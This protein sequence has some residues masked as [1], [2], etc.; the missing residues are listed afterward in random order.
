MGSKVWGLGSRGWGLEATVL[1]SRCKVWGV[2][3]RGGLGSRN[4][5]E[6]PGYSRVKGRGFL[7]KGFGAA[8]SVLGSRVQG[9]ARVQSQGSRVSGQRFRVK[10][11]GS[12]I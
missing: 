2:R 12:N 11:L 3:F 7:V 5:V 8:G 1:R 9:L 4:S 6:G 10:G